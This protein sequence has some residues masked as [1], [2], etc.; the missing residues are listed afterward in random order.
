MVKL[1]DSPAVANMVHHS[2]HGNETA[3]RITER[4]S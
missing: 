2:N 1:G 3:F 4:N